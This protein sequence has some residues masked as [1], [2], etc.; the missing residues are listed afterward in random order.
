M[1]HP[2]GPF[3][4]RSVRASVLKPPVAMRDF[5][6]ADS[7]QVDALGIAAF[8]QYQHFYN[9]WPA[10]RE[11]I[12]HL[13]SLAEHGEIVDAEIDGR[14]VGSVAYIGPGKPKSPFYQPQWAVMRM[15]VVAP[16]AQGHGIGRMLADECIG[17]ARRDKA[18]VF[19]LHTSEMMKVALPMYLRMGFAR[20]ASAPT[21]YGVAYAVYTKILD[22]DASPGASRP[23]S[24]KESG[25]G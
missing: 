1:V 22:P 11:R 6:P 4:R 20:H 23:R 5:L 19:A 9:D 16:E 2:A 17:R 8:E 24:L 13:S 3:D 18:G 10:L 7:A 21:T 15:L 12:A 25:G 14:I